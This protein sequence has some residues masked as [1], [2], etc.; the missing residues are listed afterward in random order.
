MSTFAVNSGKKELK[1]KTG[2]EHKWLVDDTKEIDN[3]NNKLKRKNDISVFIL[4]CIKNLDIGTKIFCKI[5]S[6]IKKY[7]NMLRLLR[8]EF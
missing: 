1:E 3:Y 2:A 6:L 5:A 7:R 4:P 8:Y